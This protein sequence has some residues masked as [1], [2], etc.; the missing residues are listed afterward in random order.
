MIQCFFLLEYPSDINPDIK[1][2]KDL[3]K[4]ENIEKKMDLDIFKKF[5]KNKKKVTDIQKKNPDSE[6][7]KIEKKVLTTARI[8]NTQFIAFLFKER[9]DLTYI[10]NNL[11]YKKDDFITLY[12]KGI[13]YGKEYYDIK[14]SCIRTSTT[15]ELEK[16]IDELDFCEREDIL[17]NARLGLLIRLLRNLQIGGCF[18]TH[19]FDFCSIKSFNIL[20]LLTLLFDKVMILK[21]EVIYC[22]GFLG[23]KKIT[24]EKIESYF[25]KNIE[26][27]P[28]VKIDDLLVYLKTFYKFRNSLQEDLLNKKFKDY[29]K[30]LYENYIDCM[31]EK[32]IS[33]KYILTLMNNFQNIFHIKKNK[34]W[35]YKYASQN[36]KVKYICKDLQNII[37]KEYPRHILEVG[38]GLGIYADCILK[39]KDVM[40]ISIDDQQEELWNNYTLKKIEKDKKK[41]DYFRLYTKDTI[42]SLQ[43]IHE[44]YGDYYFDLVLIDKNES[45]D[46][47]LFNLYYVKKLIKITGYIMFDNIFSIGFIKLMDFI[48][49]NYKD[50]ERVGFN[51]FKKVKDS[52]LDSDDYF[53][54]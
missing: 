37:D 5:S 26:I 2:I 22:N 31:I 30:K 8:N 7:G 46:K 20:Y 28:M 48:E 17:Y 47:L 13:T 9:Y 44:K 54:F 23:E 49:K 18:T 40:L 51:V 43:E 32:D 3:K 38:L 39:K 1:I 15:G 24:R 33:Y 34:D 19:I 29:I 27:E 52:N 21:G 45:F 10:I 6:L 35:L 12:H 14:F 36:N 16:V 41:R 25:E 53:S 4:I 50:L 11:N 42:K